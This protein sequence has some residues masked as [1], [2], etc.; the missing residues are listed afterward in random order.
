MTKRTIEWVILAVTIAVPV[1]AWLTYVVGTP[2]DFDAFF[3]VFAIA[4]IGGA[5]LQLIFMAYVRP[6]GSLRQ[7][8]AFGA[9][10]GSERGAWIPLVAPAVVIGLAL[11]IVTPPG[12]PVDDFDSDMSLYQVI[13]L[14]ALLALALTAIGAGV[15][16]LLIVMPLGFLISGLLPREERER[17]PSTSPKLTRSQLVLAALFLFSAVGF[18]VSMASV[19]EGTSQSSRG[20]MGEDLVAFVTGAGNPIAT[21]STWLFI[22][23]IV[24]I[25]IVS[26]RVEARLR[27]Q[28]PV[29]R[30]DPEPSDSADPGEDAAH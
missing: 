5:T 6:R 28:R 21:I 13:P 2:Q 24:A 8:L 4:T 20:R 14:M 30:Q 15:V 23:A 10:G 26:N 12:T 19:T 1:W 9:R 25:V 17:D 18:A 3:L 16:F 27:R 29:R 7:R 22:V 11:L